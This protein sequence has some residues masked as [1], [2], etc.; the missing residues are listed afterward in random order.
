MQGR[1]LR[2]FLYY[3]VVMGVDISVLNFIMSHKEC[4]KGNT[5][6]IG[7]QGL[8][9]AGSWADR[10]G[11][12]AKI[13]NKILAEHNAGFTAEDTVNGGD[14]HT[15]KLFKMLGAETVD[16]VDYSPYEN[17]TIV[18]DLNKPVD[19]SLHNKFD[20]ILDAGTMEHIFDV[21]TVIENYKNMLRDNGVIAI[22]TC[23]NNFAGHGF[24]QF[25]PE[26]FRT[27][28]SQQAGY[29]TISLHLYELVNDE[30]F[31]V[32]EITEPRK[33]DRQEFQTT[34]KPHYIAFAARKVDQTFNVNYQQSDYLK[35][36]GELK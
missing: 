28:F 32:Y 13:S 23:C 12:K 4:I 7:R 21:R 33:G 6:Q 1:T 35:V 2:P 25:S 29:Q 8:H 19:Q 5:L 15:E 14:G 9:Y 31:E 24:Y 22:L 27:V 18:H 16:T 34:D 11:S 3:E 17:C 20:Y 26:F 36:W 30:S 10:T